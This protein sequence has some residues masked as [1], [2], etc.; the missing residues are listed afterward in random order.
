M[1]TR[2]ADGTVYTHAGPE[3][4]VASTKA[5]TSQLVALQ[6]LALYMAQVRGTL[7]AASIR[8]HIEELLQLPHIIEH[9]VKASAAMEKVAETVLQPRPISCSWAAA[10]TIRSRSK[11]RSS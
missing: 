3:I 9:A 5:F 10:S 7:D 8:R 11:A 2:E 4:G 1:A 6:L